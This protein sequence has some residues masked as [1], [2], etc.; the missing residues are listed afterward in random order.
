MEEIQSALML[1]QGFDPQTTEVDEMTRAGDVMGRRS[2]PGGG[3]GGGG[4]QMGQMMAMGGQALT[5][6]YDV[7]TN[8]DEEG[9]T[10]V[11]WDSVKLLG[12]IAAMAFSDR[13]LK[14]NIRQIG[15]RNGT[16]WYSYD[17]LWDEDG[18]GNIGVMADEVPHAAHT[19]PS[20]FLMVDYSKVM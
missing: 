4:N 2:A 8:K 1:Q 6:T 18:S 11:D 14:K 15:I 16:N 10:S 7:F 3:G 19:H 12:Q 9:D 5:D 20:G 13:R 17:Y